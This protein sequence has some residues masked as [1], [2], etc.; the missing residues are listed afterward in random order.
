MGL[1]VEVVGAEVGVQLHPASDASSSCNREWSAWLA[2]LFR[3]DTCMVHPAYPQ[4]C[5]KA[6]LTAELATVASCRASSTDCLLQPLV[7][8]YPEPQPPA[9]CHNEHLAAHPSSCCCHC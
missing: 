9:D 8:P 6:D 7:P 5:T 2:C 4:N 1:E 3:C